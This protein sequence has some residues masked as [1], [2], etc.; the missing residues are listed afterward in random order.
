METPVEDEPPL[1][2]SLHDDG[3]RVEIRAG[4]E[5]WRRDRQEIEGMFSD[6]AKLQVDGARHAERIRHMMEAVKPTNRRFIEI[7]T[8]EMQSQAREGRS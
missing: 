4:I 3:N 5:A 6:E 7:L 1:L 8:E 2:A